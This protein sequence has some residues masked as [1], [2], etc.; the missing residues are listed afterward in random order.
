MANLDLLAGVKVVEIAEGIA[1]PMCGKIFQD[2][3]AG[4]VRIEPPGGDWLRRVGR[5]GKGGEPIYR[6]LNDGKQVVGLDLATSEGRD[7]VLELVR[8]ADIC[9][10][11]QRQRSHEKLGLAYS[12]L[13]AVAPHLV[14]C[15]VSGWGSGGPMADRAASELAV[16]VA[17]GLTRYLGTPDG[18]PVRQG[19]DL[20]SV[21][22]GVAAAQAVLAA[23]LWRM[24]SGEGQHVEVSMLATAVALMQWDIA[25]ESDPDE[26]RG[27]QLTA[28]DW[29]PDHGFQCADARCLIDLMT[30]GKAWAGLLRDIGCPE[31]A[32]DPRFSTAEGLDLHVTELP[33]LTAA[34]L[35]S[36][37]F[38]DLEKLVREKYEGTIVP[39]LSLSAAVDHPQVRHIGVIGADRRFHFPIQVS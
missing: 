11:G 9:V 17:A 8:D 25:A 29:P 4:V 37:S 20:V 2:L 38:A 12:R 14:Y 18:P 23:Y 39:M 21:D 24:G 6:Q 15:H 35:L 7:K 34:R 10:V 36:W 3:G 13:K 26:W 22:T 33:A 27:R 30:D 32:D 1:G 31:L 28:Q 19:F 16:Q 5:D